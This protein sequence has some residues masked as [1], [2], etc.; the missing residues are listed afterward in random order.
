MQAD[1]EALEMVARRA[2][3]SMRDAQSLLDQLLAFGG[4][5]LTAEQV[6]SLLG[7][8]RDDL[9]LGLASA[10][11]NHDPKRALEQLDQA[12]EEGFQMGELLDQLIA[13]WRDLMVIQCAG[14][15]AKDLSVAPRHRETLTNQSGAV[16]LD[17]ILAGLDV[18][19]STKM[20]LRGSNHGRV[21]M[22][23][24]LVRLG[25]LDDLVS[26]AQVAQSAQFPES[27]GVATPG[28]A[29]QRRRRRM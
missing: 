17:T 22:E 18:L 16:K 9:V 10:V 25:R 8:A 3:G 1:D 11:L 14:A 4:D 19:N 23:M 7:T 6:H 21:L 28:L 24:A 13:Y 26:L 5:R 29:P 27:P 20:R 2:G 12:A 15:E